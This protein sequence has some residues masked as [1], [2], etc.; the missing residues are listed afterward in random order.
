MLNESELNVAVDIQQRTYNL[1]MWL[2]SAIA[3]G[4]V[5]VESA[6]TYASDPIIAAQ[7]ISEHYA[8]IP[9]ECRPQS[10]HDNDITP[11]A[12][13]FSSYLLASFDI[14]ELPGNRYVPHNLR[15][16]QTPLSFVANPYLKPKKL[17]KGDKIRA[18]KL[19]ADYLIQL[20]FDCGHPIDENRAKAIVENA[21]VK[22]IAA[23][24]TYG[25]RLISR[26]KGNIEGSALLALWREFAWNAEGSP[27]KNFKLD[28]QSI[29]SCEAA[30]AAKICNKRI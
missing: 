9:R 24:A 25:E 20:A 19:K 16:P 7:W 18:Q 1:F 28:A 17:T 13:M 2:N 26:M 5:S 22:E 15:N 30:L 8:N 29:L 11:Y 14:E 10:H 3:Q 4:V 21:E 27:R 23:I 12:R 6:R